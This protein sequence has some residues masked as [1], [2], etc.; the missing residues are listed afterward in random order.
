M[1]G[2]ERSITMWLTLYNISAS[3]FQGEFTACVCMCVMVCVMVVV[4][5]CVHV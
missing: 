1:R 5:V 3:H 4:C 2:R